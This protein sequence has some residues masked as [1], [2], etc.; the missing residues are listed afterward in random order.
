MRA[1]LAAA[2]LLVALTSGARAQ[3]PECSAYSG[4]AARVCGAAVDGTRAFAPMLGLLESGGNAVLGTANTLGGPG[5]FSLTA[6]VNAVHVVLPKVS[7]DGSTSTVPAGED[8]VAPGPVAEAALGVYGGLPSG[9]LSVDLL[10]SAQLLPT[11]RFEG[12]AVERDAR[13]IGTVALGLGYGARIGVVR[14]TGPLPA[15]SVSVM[16]RDIP[17][18]TYGDVNAGDQFQYSVE[19]YATNLR[20]VASKQL[21]VLGVAAGLGWDKY[22]GEALIQ[23][24]NPGSPGLA[25]E[26]PL[27]LS[28]SRT[29]AFLDAGLDL[30]ALR[31]IAEGGYQAGRNQHLSTQ[32]EKL[33]TSKGK[34]F[35]GLGLRLGL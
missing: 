19:L 26:V 12:L 29:L 9:A 27:D 35:A 28:T 4:D 20:L 6:R 2:L 32:F 10:A 22:S 8:L 31:L 16:R 21:T 30:S 15:I 3:A 25:T 14:E 18:L 24:R 34:F 23:V 5:H 33:D 17:T 1:S 7:Y 11:S 13:R